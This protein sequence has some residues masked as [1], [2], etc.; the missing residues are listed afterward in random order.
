MRVALID[1]FDTLRAYLGSYYVNDFNYFGRTWQVNVQADAP[2]RGRGNQ[3]TAQ[4]PQ[5]RRRHGTA[6]TTG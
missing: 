3:Q 2:F 6:G 4:G 1:V 5:R